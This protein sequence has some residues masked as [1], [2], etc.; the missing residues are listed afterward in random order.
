MNKLSNISIATKIVSAVFFSAVLSAGA[1]LSGDYTLMAVSLF[2][3]LAFAALLAAGIKRDIL[4]L[5]EGA[6]LVASGNYDANFEMS[7]DTEIG[8]LSVSLNNMSARFRDDLAMSHSIQTSIQSPLFTADRNTVLTFLNQAAA[9]LMDVLPEDVIG[10][11]TTKELFGSDRATRSALSGQPMPAYEVSIRN[12]K[13]ESIPVIASS[14]PIRNARGEIV[15][16]FLTFIDLRKSMIRQREYL[17]QQVKPIEEAVMAVAEGDLA[18]SVQ[19]GKDG[20]LYELGRKVQQMITDLRQ[21]LLHVS[22]T[23]NSV[24]SSASQIS[25]S[26]EELAAGSQEQSA[27]GSE[28]AAAVE[29]MTR[30]VIENSRNAANAAEVARTSGA[31]AKEG[32]AV[33]EHTV[34]KIRE[35]ADVIQSS[36]S[37]VERL[38]A[39]TDQIGEIISV[40]DDIANQT[41][42]LALNAAIEA[43]RAGEEG[44]GF[45]VVADEVRNLAE[46]TTQATKQ[47]ASMIKNLQAE[48]AEAVRSMRIGNEVVTEGI[49]LADKAGVSLKS[50]VE[51]TDRTVDMITQI[52]AASEQQSATSEEISKNVESISTVSNESAAGISQIAKAADDLS[53]LTESLRNLVYRFRLDRE[54]AELIPN[55]DPTGSVFDESSFRTAGVREIRRS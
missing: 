33:V 8:R 42:L 29:E 45:A 31:A 11:K 43:A 28:V 27:Q 23:S 53:R 7:T 54:S 15:G 24:A 36:A 46:R 4:K 19:I 21:T 37:T 17:E 2:I 30:T 47:I 40:I 32:G 16:S 25:S 52:A 14:G 26:T 35:I 22:E 3:C 38:G 55:V 44:R 39:S 13:G 9:E 12:H 51:N 6:D 49:S 18:V 48:A 20:Q 50:I 10:K 5:K 1:S 34:K 41:N